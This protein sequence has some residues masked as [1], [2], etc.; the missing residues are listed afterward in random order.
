MSTEGLL[1]A[2]GAWGI[3]MLA[4]G[5]TLAA[6]GHAQA[7]ATPGEWGV[8]DRILGREGK[9]QP[10][11]VHKY[12]FPRG[13]LRVT[14]RGIA[15][16]PTLALGSW[17]AFKG[18][19][20]D[21]MA[22]GDLVL[23]EREVTPVLTKLQGSGVQQTALHNHLL[24]ESPRVMYLHIEAHGAA[25]KLAEAIRSAL[26]LTG[27]PPAK[28]PSAQAP[29]A[30]PLDTERLKTVL[31]YSGTVNGGVYQ[32]SVARA[33]VVRAGGM[34]VPPAM[35]VATAINFQPTGGGKAAITGDFVLT[36]K[37]VNPVIE[38][39]RDGGIEVTAVHSHMLTEEPRLFFLHYW[40]N[41]D[42]I[43]LARA[44]RSALDRIS[45]KKAGP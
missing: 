4:V 15:I 26:V 10:G 37:E 8:V 22:M 5:L 42:A 40:A 16:K 11:G 23:T 14:M 12:S 7:P 35:G 39:L 30:F 20:S 13:D 21:T 36:A 43:A 44:L 19:A 18:T 27:T 38:K 41:A 29:A 1:D 3:A 25:T 31:G 28:P 9:T 2:S 33:E 32:V 6:T 34:E 17:I 45:V 24:G